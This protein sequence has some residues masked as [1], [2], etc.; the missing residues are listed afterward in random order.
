[1]TWWSD[2]VVYQIYPRSFADANGDGVGDLEGIRAHLDHL[3]W[4]GVDAIWLS[5]IQRSPMKDFG[6][7][8]ADYCAIDDLFGSLADF[9]RLLADAHARGIRVLLDWVPNHSSD[10][11]PWFVES[12]ASR[13]SPRRDWYVWRDPGPDGGPPNNWYSVFGGGAW[14]WDARTGQY[15]LH[16]FLREQPEL[17]WR[18]PELVAAM[19][20][21]LRFWLDRGVD[22]FRIDVIHALAKDPALRDNPAIE[23]RP[24]GYFGQSL[25]HS[26]N[27]PDVHE[28]VRGIRGV[29]D[30]YDER[31]AVGEVYIM[32]PTEVAKYY[33][34]GDELHLA[35]NFSVMKTPWDANGFREQI[36]RMEA[37]LP[38]DWGWPTL[39][40]SSHDEPRHASRYDH[41]ELGEARARLAAMLLLT[42][43]GTPFL[44]YGEEIGM[45]NVEIPPDRIRDPVGINIHPRASRDPERTPMLWSAGPGAGFGSSEPWLPLGPDAGRRSVEAQRGD[46]ASLLHLYRDL[47]ALR[48][49][50][51]ALQRGSYRGLDAPPGVFAYERRDGAQVVRVVLN[52][53]DAPTRW[54]GGEGSVVAGLRTAYGRPLPDTPDV[55]LE[56]AEGMVLVVAP[57]AG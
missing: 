55:D 13:V 5:P 22:G 50:T 53:G 28:V 34:K 9:D 8:V 16:T 15:Y 10:R 19:H 35:F 6:Y 44:Y 31:M 17:N 7:D 36:E 45:R 39:V 48:R 30:E 4:L 52:F 43:R 29:L 42:L 41:P 37:L 56:P 27:H 14:T 57:L 51:P 32:D 23:G 12:R 40:L 26:Q 24:A 49:A 1:M 47:L 25:V 20:D 38:P 11:H 54:S 2:G 3:A 21:T 33:G 18:S 46:P